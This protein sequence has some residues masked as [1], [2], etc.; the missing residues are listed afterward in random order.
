MSRVH[1]LPL[2]SDANVP[3]ESAEI[4]ANN[5]VAPAVLMA[6][7]VPPEEL[8]AVKEVWARSAMAATPQ[9]CW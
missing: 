3:G 1:E 2:L 7:V 9:S 6:G 8:V 5:S 4:H